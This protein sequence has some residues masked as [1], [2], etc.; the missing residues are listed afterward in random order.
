MKNKIEYITLTWK[1]TPKSDENI[2]KFDCVT[3]IIKNK[4]TELF[5]ALEFIREEFWLVWWK[6]EKWE[7]KNEAIIREIEEETGYKKAEIKKILF[8][9]IHSRWYKA[10]KNREEEALDKVFYVEVEEKYKS[11]II[12][13]DV[14]TESIHWFNEKEMLEKLTLTHHIYFFEEFLKNKIN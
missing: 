6:L 12:W 5:L 10:R 2:C 7:N 8:E 13:A 1:S 9:E 14:W 11:E 3:A 4:D